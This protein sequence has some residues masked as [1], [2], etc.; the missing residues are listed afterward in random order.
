ME[1]SSKQHQRSWAL[2]KECSGVNDNSDYTEENP[3]N[4]HDEKVIVLHVLRGIFPKCEHT[5]N[6]LANGI[7][8]EATKQAS[9]AFIRCEPFH[10]VPNA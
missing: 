1:E 6:N 7:G 2:L 9:V 5:K 4:Q 10:M 8:D 3:R